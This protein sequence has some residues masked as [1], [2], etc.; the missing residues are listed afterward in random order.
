M[1]VKVRSFLCVEGRR[2]DYEFARYLISRELS[3][4]RNTPDERSAR[5]ESIK[6]SSSMAQT[7][8]EK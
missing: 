7:T 3:L 5:E 2:I 8:E 6:S 4:K 1:P